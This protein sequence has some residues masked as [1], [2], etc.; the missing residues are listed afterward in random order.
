M[1]KHYI[2]CSETYQ[3][4]TY[5][6]HEKHIFFENCEYDISKPDDELNDNSFVMKG[7][8]IKRIHLVI[9]MRWPPSK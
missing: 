3:G 9:Y 1:T 6:H 7:P 8:H 5:G 4:A 2:D